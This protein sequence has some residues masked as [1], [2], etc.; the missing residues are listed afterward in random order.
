MQKFTKE[1]IKSGKTDINERTR[2][3]FLNPNV[4]TYEITNDDTIHIA[5]PIYC[6]ESRSISSFK[7][8]K[9]NTEQSRKM[10]KSEDM[11]ILR[12][13]LTNRF[14]V[15][16]DVILGIKIPPKIIIRRDFILEHIKLVF[17]TFFSLVNNFFF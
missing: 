9:E 6:N 2:K 15:L 1:N 16:L 4:L 3:L 8:R 12:A 14:L 11:I 17:F 5:V 13:Y 7:S 10:L